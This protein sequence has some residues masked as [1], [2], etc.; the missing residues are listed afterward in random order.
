[1][2]AAGAG[3]F[4]TPHAAAGGR[5]G[6]AVASVLRPSLGVAL[7][8][9]VL[10]LLALPSL[11][12]AVAPLLLERGVAKAAAASKAV[13]PWYPER[14]IDPDGVDL[15]VEFK[16]SADVGPIR[17]LDE[18]PETVAPASTVTLSPPPV[19]GP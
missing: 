9:A 6:G 7:S 13:K 11:L 16:G 3:L 19:V 12:L 2:V 8:T 1:A 10:V 17:Y 18:A 14:R 5:V 4:S 15:P